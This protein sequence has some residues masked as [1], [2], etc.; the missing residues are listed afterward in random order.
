MILPFL[1]ILL[2]IYSIG[3]PFLVIISL[4]AFPLAWRAIQI[5]WRRYRSFQDLIPA[6]ALTIQTL[7][8]MGLLI[9]GALFM[10]RIIGR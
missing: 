3:L 4:G 2:L 5:L 10:S 8:S 7:V 6:Q 1:A 9:S